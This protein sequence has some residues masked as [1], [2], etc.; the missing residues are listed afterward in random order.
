MVVSGYSSDAQLLG[1]LCTWSK[2]SCKEERKVNWIQMGRDDYEKCPDQSQK[3]LFRCY[4]Y[5]LLDCMVSAL[6]NCSMSHSSL[7]PSA[8]HSIYVD[9]EMCLPMDT[10][11]LNAYGS[12]IPKVDKSKI[13]V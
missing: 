3:L 1:R 10:I 9:G 13:S 4:H 12:I 11:S 7:S 2:I 6:Q 8:W 5:Y